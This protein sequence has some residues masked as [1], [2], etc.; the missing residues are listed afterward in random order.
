[1]YTLII[2]SNDMFLL[3]KEIS[4]SIDRFKKCGKTILGNIYFD[5]CWF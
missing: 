1:M 4:F 3:N 2:D 5:K